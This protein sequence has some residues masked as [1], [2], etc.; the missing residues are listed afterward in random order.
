M[1]SKIAC[2][3]SVSMHDVIP[4]KCTVV[5]NEVARHATQTYRVSRRARGTEP[6]RRSDPRSAGAFISHGYR[7]GFSHHVDNR[8]LDQRQL[9]NFNPK[10][11]FGRSRGGTRARTAAHF[12]ADT[13]RT[14]DYS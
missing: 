2:W 14:L 6:R 13:N 8:H 7:R 3:R 5:N 10:L 12:I 11:V 9:Q 4:D 1:K